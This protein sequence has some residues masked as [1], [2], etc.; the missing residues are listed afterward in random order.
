M[1]LLFGLLLFSLALSCVPATYAWPQDGTGDEFRWQGVIAD[2]KAIEIKGVNGEVR[3]EAASGN[4]V[5]VVATKRWGR[6]DPQSVNVK[7]VE[8]ANG[9]TICAVYPGRN[10]EPGHCQPGGGG[11]SAYDNDVKVEFS[12]RVPAGVRFIGRTVNGGV[13]AKSLGSNVEAYTVNGNVKVSTA[14]HA[15]ARTVNGSISVACGRADWNE[16][17]EFNTVN[18][19]IELALP[20]TAQTEIQAR[21]VNGSISTELP[22]F[23]RGKLNTRHLDGII[24]N[25]ESRNGRQL[26]METVNGSI[27]V[28]RT[29]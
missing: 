13:T 24:G 11:Q 21:T 20:E 15:Q 8:H 4:Q 9:V 2:G 25:S 27:R 18:G 17:L 26:K 16:A 3:A 7:L 22:L 1:K 5:E 12:V 23:V 28:N 19:S 10:G 6:S 14:G 29:M